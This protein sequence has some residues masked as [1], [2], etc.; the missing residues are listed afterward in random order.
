MP[1]RI[2]LFSSRTIIYGRRTVDSSVV[3][4]RRWNNNVVV[5]VIFFCLWCFL[6][7][8]RVPVKNAREEQENKKDDEHDAKD[9]GDK[10]THT[11]LITVWVIDDICHKEL[12]AV[13]GNRAIVASGE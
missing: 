1:T 10:P 12:R 2:L 4:G 7:G 11:S 8:V 5:V 9:D 13:S 3:D 6:N